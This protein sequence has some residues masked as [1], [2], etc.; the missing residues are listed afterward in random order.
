MAV[1]TSKYLIFESLPPCHTTEESRQIQLVLPP[2]RVS[3]SVFLLIIRISF[4]A[5]AT[6][7]N[8]AKL[9]F[10]LTKSK[11]LLLN[12]FDPPTHSFP[13]IEYATYPGHVAV[14]ISW[15]FPH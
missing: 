6:L 10:S 13:G 9:V 4:A 11:T 3:V 5:L 12:N 1:I 15:N 14:D 8:A 7:L 2:S